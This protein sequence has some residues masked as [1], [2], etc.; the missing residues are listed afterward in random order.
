[1]NLRKN[2]NCVFLFNLLEIFSDRFLFINDIIVEQSIVIEFIFAVWKMVLFFTLRK[3]I[4]FAKWDLY[5]TS[6]KRCHGSDLIFF[7]ETF[8][9]ELLTKLERNV[10]NEL[11]RELIRRK[12]IENK[13]SIEYLLMDIERPNGVFENDRPFVVN[14]NWEGILCVVCIIKNKR[15]LH[16]QTCSLFHY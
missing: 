1:M 8:D 14:L 4:I 3:T 6:N 5:F 15:M 7:N 9:E 16:G 10:E 12:I 11:N 13:S 2:R